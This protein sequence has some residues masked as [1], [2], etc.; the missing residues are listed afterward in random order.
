MKL[1]LSYEAPRILYF[2]VSLTL[3]DLGFRVRSFCGIVEFGD[4]GPIRPT[5]KGATW[6]IRTACICGV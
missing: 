5:L 1:L 2:V 4:G 3:A 6:E